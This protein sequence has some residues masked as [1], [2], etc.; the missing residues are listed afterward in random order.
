MM[1]LAII[2]EF[3]ALPGSEREVEVAIRKVVSQTKREP[4]CLAIHA[5]KSSRDAALFFIHSRWTDETAFEAH[6]GL[7][8]TL[9]FIETVEPLITAQKVEVQRLTLI[10]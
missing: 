10:A 3:R 4:D 5:F 2:G 6:A 8:H 1:E 9:Q 7:P